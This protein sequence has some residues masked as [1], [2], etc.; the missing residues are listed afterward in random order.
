[1]TGYSAEMQ[2]ENAVCDRKKKTL[3]LLCPVCHKGFT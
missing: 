1:M 3:S 2:T